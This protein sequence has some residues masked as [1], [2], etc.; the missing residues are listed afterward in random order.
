[1]QIHKLKNKRMSQYEKITVTAESVEISPSSARGVEVTMMC[2]I[3]SLCNE[4]VEMDGFFDEMERLGY[5]L[6]E[7]EEKDLDDFDEEDIIDY[8]EGKGYEVKEN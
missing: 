4:L 5:A 6:E 7:R 2:G 3:R 8:L 1:M